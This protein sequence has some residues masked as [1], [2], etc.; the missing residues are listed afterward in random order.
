MHSGRGMYRGEAQIT[1]RPWGNIIYGTKYI[2]LSCIFY[3]VIYILLY[4]II[5]YIIEYII[6][7]GREC[8]EMI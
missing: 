5:L 4:H 7:H 6:M 2:L 3:Y 1:S 8:D